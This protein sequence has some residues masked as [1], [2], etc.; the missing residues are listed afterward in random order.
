VQRA[1]EW[2]IR[3]GKSVSRIVYGD[4]CIQCACAVDDD[5]VLYCS[6]DA[7]IKEGTTDVSESCVQQAAAP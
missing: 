7:C 4:A 5:G 6:E 1:Y 3:K 2:H